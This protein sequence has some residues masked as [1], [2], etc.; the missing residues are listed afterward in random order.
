MSILSEI[1]VVV[2]TATLVRKGQLNDK[3]YLDL[4]FESTKL[5]FEKCKKF[6]VSKF[7]FMNTMSVYGLTSST[8]KINIKS[9]ANPITNYAKSKFLSEQY[10]LSQKSTIKVSIIRLPSVYGNNAPG[11]FGDLE[12]LALDIFHCHFSELK[13][14]DQWLMLRWLLK[15]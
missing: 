12:Q 13:I 8:S 2:H 11:N 1:D 14:R 7:I 10:L 4:K 9:L 5:L 6:S 3:E 15:F